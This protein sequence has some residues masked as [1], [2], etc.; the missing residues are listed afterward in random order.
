VPPGSGLIWQTTV[1]VP[2]KLWVL[3]AMVALAIEGDYRLAKREL[4]LRG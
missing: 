4:R 1:T 2:D 3:A